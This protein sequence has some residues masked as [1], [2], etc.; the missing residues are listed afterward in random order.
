MLVKL[1]LVHLCKK[2]A[3]FHSRVVSVKAGI[4]TFAQPGDSHQ[5]KKLGIEASLK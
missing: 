3:A 4:D 1:T 2:V 5:D